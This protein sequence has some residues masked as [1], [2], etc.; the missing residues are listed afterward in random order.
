[1]PRLVERALH[2]LRALFLRRRADSSL[3]G[4]IA[5]HL[6]EAEREYRARGLTPAEA[7]LAARRDFGAIALIEDQCRDTRRVAVVQSLLQDLR[8]GLRGLLAQ[9]LLTIAAVASIGAGAGATAFVFGL[10]SELLLARPTAR[11]VDAL[12]NITLDRNSHVSYRNWRAL[13]ESGVLAGLAGYHIEGSIT[14]RHGDSTVA[15][16]PLLAT[17]NFFDVLGVPMAL[18]RGFTAAEAAAEREPRIVVVSDRFWRLRLGGDHQAVGRPIVINGEPY[19]VLGVLPAGLKAIPGFGLAPELYV[20]LSRSVLPGLDRPHGAAAQLVGRLKPGQSV[21]QAKAALD[22]VVQRRHL[23]ASDRPRRVGQMVPVTDGVPGMGSMWRFFAMLGA[24]GAMV[25]GI[26]CANVAGLLLA[27]NT[28]RRKELALRAALGASRGRIVQQLLVEALWLATL[29]TACGIAVM[30]VAMAAVGRVPLPLPLPFELSVSLDWRLFGLML[31]MVVLATVG[32]GVL[33]ALQGARPSLAPALKQAE[34]TYVHRRWTA[35]GLLVVGQVTIS[36]ALVVTALLFVRN[37]SMAH[38]SNLGFDTMRTLVA[39]IGLVE[40]RYTPERRVAYLQDVVD[41]V[42]AVPGIERAAFAFGM[43]LTV[44]HGRTSGAAIGIA[45][46]PASANVQA[47]WAENIVSPGYFDTLGI[48]RRQGRDFARTDT[49]GTPR[50]VIVNEAFVERY[51]AGRAPIGLHVMLPG[52][53]DHDDYEIVGVVAN[54]RHRTVG[55]A[56]MAAIYYAYPQRPT[57]GRVLHVLAR[58]AGDPAAAARS[59]AAAIGPVDPSAAVDVQTVSQSLA[60]AFLP[61]RVGAALLG[62]LG[63]IGLTL[64]MAGLFAMV[65]YSV[66]RRTK[67]IGVRMALGAPAGAVVRLVVADAVVLVASGLAIGLTLAA[68]VTQPLATLL[69]D[70]L[71][72]R[73]PLTFAGAALLLALAS[74]AATI[75]PVRRAIGVGPLVALR[76]E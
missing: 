51:L 23:E 48:A 21:E 36:V 31:T 49:A 8:H 29:G 38:Q 60:F 40:H 43:P 9:P 34:R 13:D 2:R 57:D 55:E 50:V 3:A 33:P 74:A 75:P 14:V 66:T 30:L 58:V 54:S 41:R 73:D 4:E 71:S 61:S 52:L 1:M 28:V 10:A 20:P 17:A 68:L 46:E 69:V 35:R 45:G 37:L 27:R 72:P 25:L 42:D 32:S 15:I 56:Q 39:Q 26:A 76:T 12:V 67:E 47:H 19:M 53:S 6:E 64:A 22:T 5:L 63:A 70:G 65:S 11:D 44:R 24:V 7:R 62:G 18:G 16:V 59:I